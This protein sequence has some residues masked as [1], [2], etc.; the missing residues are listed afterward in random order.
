MKIAITKVV[1]EA[2]NYIDSLT[3]WACSGIP[4]SQFI[5]CDINCDIDL[6]CEAQHN[7]HLSFD[8]DD[9]SCSLAQHIRGDMY[10][11]LTSFVK[12]KPRQRHI[13]GLIYPGLLPPSF[14]LPN[15][16]SRLVG[17]SAD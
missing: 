15:R 5:N 7:S 4:C 1:A 17:N 14:T 12:Q 10:I 13:L 9:Y 16:N 11:T 3:L 8:E 6:T 2:E